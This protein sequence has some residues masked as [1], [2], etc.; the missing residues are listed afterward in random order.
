MRTYALCPMYVQGRWARDEGVD[1]WHVGVL[2]CRTC[3]AS[4]VVAALLRAFSFC[5]SC[6]W[7]RR[8]CSADGYSWRRVG[9]VVRTRS[10]VHE[11]TCSMGQV[12]TACKLAWPRQSAHKYGLDVH[13]EMLLTA[14]LRQ[15][16]LL[17]AIGAQEG[18]AQAADATQQQGH[19][20][21]GND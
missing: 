5:S 1:A 6:S 19:S 20:S 7:A 16:A 3:S 21:P 17:A 9:L 12:T 10:G 8:S 2:Q 13:D 15:L 4:L 11:T 14:S 18:C